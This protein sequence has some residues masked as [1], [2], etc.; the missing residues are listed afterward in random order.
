MLSLFNSTFF[1]NKK[2]VGY[3]GITTKCPDY[4]ANPNNI[5]LNP[6]STQMFQVV[7]GFLGEMAGI[8]SDNYFHIGG[9]EVVYGCLNEDQSVRNWMKSKGFTNL[10]QVMQYYEN[11][12]W[13]LMK[14]MNKTII[15]WEEIFNAYNLHD[16]PSD[17]VIE[18]WK[19]ENTLLQVADA[20]LRGLLAYGWYLYPYTLTWR[21]FYNNEP[22]ASSSWTPQ[23]EKFIIGG[24]V[25]AWG[26]YVIYF[27]FLFFH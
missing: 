6:S 5:A 2:G 19:D 20:G 24:E 17:I 23:T 8:F 1:K 26:E 15:A 10:D 25:C 14:K 9:D 22:F 21:D 4:A 3:P 11:E 18:V 27:L 13:S 7:E 12:I 16:Y